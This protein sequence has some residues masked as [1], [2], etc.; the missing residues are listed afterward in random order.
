MTCFQWKVSLNKYPIIVNPK[1][2]D[3]NGT[4]DLNNGYHSGLSFQISVQVVVCY[5]AI[6]A[7]L[8][9]L[10]TVNVQDTFLSTQLF[11]MN[12]DD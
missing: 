10:A 8:H 6:N 3:G 4:I 9:V 5:L 1:P 2:W 7:K 12:N 11:V